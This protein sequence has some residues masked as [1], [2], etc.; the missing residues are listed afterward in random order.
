MNTMAPKR[1]DRRFQ[2]E[3]DLHSKSVN[4]E[5]S[6]KRYVMSVIRVVICMLPGILDNHDSGEL[7]H[8]Q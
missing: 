6:R 7:T 3:T 5:R 1:M 8:V 4:T 2:G